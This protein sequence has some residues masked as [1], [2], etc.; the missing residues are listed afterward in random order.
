MF[1]PRLGIQRTTVNGSDSLL[2]GCRSAVP[3]EFNAC[4]VSIGILRDL[5]HG[6][7][8]SCAR[9]NGGI[10]CC[11]NQQRTD[12]L[13][14]LNRQGIIAKL[15]SGDWSGHCSPEGCDLKVRRTQVRDLAFS[16]YLRSLRCCAT[17]VCKELLKR[18]F[19]LFVN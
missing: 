18:S 9:V 10:R 6:C 7:T 4:Q 11:R 15:Q 3:V 14:F 12:I 2:G 16:V 19:S 1:P 13:G 8:I 5:Q 17:S